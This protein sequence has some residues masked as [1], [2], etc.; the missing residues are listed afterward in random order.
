MKVTSVY[1]MAVVGFMA[2]RAAQAMPEDAFN[3]FSLTNNPNGPW[4]YGYGV[5]GTSFTAYPSSATNCTGIAGLNCWDVSTNSIPYVGENVTGSPIDDGSLTIPTGS[6]DIHPFVSPYDTIIEWT[7][8]STGNWQITGFYDLLDTSASGTTALIYA[9]A[10]QLLD[11]ALATSNRSVEFS[12]TEALAS[13]ETLQFAEGPNSSGGY[14]SDS[15]GFDVTVSSV[16]EPESVALLCT[17][18]AGFGL[19]PR[20]KTAQARSTRR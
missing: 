16:P 13:G 18:L 20:R 17:A 11:E 19:I 12:F 3:D 9:G 8:P 5:P 14:Y 7:A 1:A 4:S 6:L 2:C 15:T 10:I